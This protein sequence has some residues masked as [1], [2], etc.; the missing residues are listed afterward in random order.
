VLWERGAA[1]SALAYALVGVVGSLLALI[2][3]LWLA[4]SLA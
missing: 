3:G 4:R 1:L 2:V